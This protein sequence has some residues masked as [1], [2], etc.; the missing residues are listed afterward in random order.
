MAE[1]VC[2]HRWSPWMK[3]GYEEEGSAFRE[4]KGCGVQQMAGEVEPRV[5]IGRLEG[6]E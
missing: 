5:V 1:I 4:C 6:V 2:V 3:L